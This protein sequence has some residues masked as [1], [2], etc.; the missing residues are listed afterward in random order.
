MEKR[1]EIR[2]KYIIYVEQLISGH[3]IKDFSIQY[4][5]Y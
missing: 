1:I 2:T 5:P 4:S 3:W